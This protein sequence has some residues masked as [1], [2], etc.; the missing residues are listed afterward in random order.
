MKLIAEK[1]EMS[2]RLFRIAAIEAR[3]L[4]DG[5]NTLSIEPAHDFV[6]P[7]AAGF[8]V[9]PQLDLHQFVVIQRRLDFRDHVFAE[10]LVRDHDN[11]LEPV[12]QAPQVT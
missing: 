9:A 4:A 10:A 2:S 6:D 7:F 3:D 12:R 5:L 11:G 8:P 1:R